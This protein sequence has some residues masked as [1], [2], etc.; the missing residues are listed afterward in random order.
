MHTEVLDKVKEK[1][2]LGFGPHL[3]LDCYSCNKEKLADLDLI[4]DTLDNF[5]TKIGMNKIMPPYV[6]RYQGT[7]PQDWGISGV[8][9]I[10]E[11]HITIHTFPDKDHA[12][13][14]IFSCKS[15]D[16]DYALNYMVNLFESKEHEVSLSSRGTEFIR[17]KAPKAPD[18]QQRVYSH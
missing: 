10:A 2:S 9:L 18:P 4:Y 3:M 8:V 11:S 17:T 6:F 13:I 1:N 16:T 12:F 15:F 5:P 14:D 7:V